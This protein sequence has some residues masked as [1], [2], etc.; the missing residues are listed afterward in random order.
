MGGYG[1]LNA[2]LKHGDVYGS[3]IALSSAIIGE[4][5]SKMKDDDKFHI[6]PYS[7]YV[8]T[9]GDPATYVG[10]DRDLRVLAKNA[11]ANPPNIYIACGTE[12][13]IGIDSNRE[14]SRLLNELGIKHLYQEGPGLHDWKFWNEYI[15]KALDWLDGFK[16]AE[17]R[18]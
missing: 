16:Q 11:A 10:S 1:A 5:L 7:Y 15:D 14:Y 13:V 3:I 8:H 12:D 2:G 9:F 6:A 18:V 17:P 4:E